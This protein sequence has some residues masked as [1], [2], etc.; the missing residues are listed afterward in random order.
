M[1]STQS[2]PFEPI[3]IVH[4]DAI[5]SETSAKCFVAQICANNTNWFYVS[6]LMSNIIIGSS[7]PFEWFIGMMTIWLI[8]LNTDLTSSSSFCMRQ[9]HTFSGYAFQLKNHCL[10]AQMNASNP[11]I[12]RLLCIF[13]SNDPFSDGI[14][15]I[16]CKNN[17]HEDSRRHCV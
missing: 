6:I 9:R 14:V 11:F 10:P 2:T 17:N 1:E 16:W 7:A 3:I 4:Y 15:R 13:E 5:M 8:E 12:H